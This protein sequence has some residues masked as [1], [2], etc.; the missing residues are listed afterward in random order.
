MGNYQAR[1]HGANVNC[2]ISSFNI[3]LSVVLEESDC[4]IIL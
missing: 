4:K 3:F 1:Y 2:P